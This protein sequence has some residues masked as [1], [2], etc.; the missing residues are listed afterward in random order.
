MPFIYAFW[1]RYSTREKALKEAAKVRKMG[2]NA[3][4]M[5]IDDHNFDVVVGVGRGGGLR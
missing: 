1:K 2:K 3:H 5:R 4:V